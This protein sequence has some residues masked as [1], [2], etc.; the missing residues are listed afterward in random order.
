MKYQDFTENWPWKNFTPEEVSCRCCGEL[1]TDSTDKI[2]AFFKNAMDKLQEL[3]H[4]WGKPITINSGHRC[5]KHNAKVGG[6]SKSQ[7]LIIAFDC[8]CPREE[9]PEFCELALEVGFHVARP[10]P[11]NGFVHLDMGRPR[12]W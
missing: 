12:T 8:V 3:R 11:D 1:W 2:P 4:R 10:Y 6:A 5:I 7:H 9:Q